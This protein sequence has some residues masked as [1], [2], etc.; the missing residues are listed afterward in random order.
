MSNRLRF[1]V[2]FGAILGALWLLAG[3]SSVR[4]VATEV[5]TFSSLQP[6]LLNAEY[7]FER[8]P[9]QQAQA[10][11]QERIEAA[12]QQALARAGMAF[13]P[14]AT[15]YAVQV[16]FGVQRESSYQAPWSADLGWAYGRG[17]GWGGRMG[18][19]GY[20]DGDYY[21]RTVY[22]HE[23][24]VTIRDQNS[25]Q[26]VYETYARYNAANADVW[27]VLAALFEA[28]LDNFPAATVGVRQL[29]IRVPRAAKTLN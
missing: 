12:A 2:H 26:I 9:S 3:C 21:G 23:V 28:S 20:W 24:G 10:A 29:D 8:L 5:Q 25:N 11:Q 22:R 6:P 18:W 1:I 7:K 14:Q 4:V 16:G 19:G 27:G 15:R 17:F 13:N